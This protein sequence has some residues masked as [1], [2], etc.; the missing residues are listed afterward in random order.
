MNKTPEYTKRAIKKYMN[1]RY[2]NN[3]EY[4]EKIK[5]KARDYSKTDRGIEQRQKYYEEKKGF[6]VMKRRYNYWNK[7]NDLETFQKKYPDDI[8]TLRQIGY[9]K[10]E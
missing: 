10:G 7:K 5:Q 1:K 4:R 6:I 8:I 9:L 2:K 3:T